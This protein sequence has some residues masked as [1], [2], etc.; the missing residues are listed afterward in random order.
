LKD[1][2]FRP[3]AL[4]TLIAEPKAPGLLIKAH[5][6]LAL[7]TLLGGALLIMHVVG[8]LAVDIFPPALGQLRKFSG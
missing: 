4:D 7:A 3:N 8:S 6:L 5:D 2:D 1:E